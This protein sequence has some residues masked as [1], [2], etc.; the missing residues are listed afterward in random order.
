MLCKEEGFNKIQAMFEHAQSILSNTAP[1]GHQA[2]NNKLKELQDKWNTSVSKMIETKN[3][4]DQNIHRWA[5]FLEQ[6]HQL[7]KTLEY[8]E[9]T[10]EEN[11]PFLATLPEKKSQLEVIKVTI[12]INTVELAHKNE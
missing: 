8:V 12:T 10:L 2:I 3:Q 9:A 1:S 6:I 7:N 5:G 11:A 4:L